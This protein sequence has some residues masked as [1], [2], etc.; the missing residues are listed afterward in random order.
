M[1]QWH[2]PPSVLDSEADGAE[3]KADGAESKAD[4]AESEADGADSEAD[5]NVLD[6]VSEDSDPVPMHEGEEDVFGCT[7]TAQPAILSNDELAEEGLEDLPWDPVE[8]RLPEGGEFELPLQEFVLPECTAKKVPR[9][10]PSNDAVNRAIPEMQELVRPRRAKG[11]GHTKSKLDLVTHTR[12]ECVLRFLRLYRTS[13][14]AAWSLHSETIA[15]TAGKRGRKTWLARKLREWAIDFCENEK[16]RKL[17]THLLGQHNSCVLTDEDVAG[18]IHQ[19]LQSLGKWV[20]AKDIA[21]YVATPEFQARLQIKR[22][23]SVRTAQRWMK[24]MGYRWRK[25]PSGMYSDGHERE[26]IVHYWQNVFLPRWRHLHSRARWWIETHSQKTIDVDA[27]L[28][29]YLS[30]SEDARV[31]VIWCHDESIFY[32]NDQRQIRWVG[33]SETPTIKAKGEGK[34]I[35]VGDYVCPD[36]GWMR[37]KTPNADGSFD[38]ARV[39][40]RPGKNR[41]GYQTIEL[42]LA[43]ATK[44]M[45]VLD[46]EYRDEHHVFAYDNARIHTARAPDGLSA[47][48]MT[49]GPSK[50]FNK[51]KVNGVQTQVRMQDARFKMGHAQC[52]YLPDGSFKGMKQLIIERRAM[53]HDLPDPDARLANGRKMRGKCL[54]FGCRNTPSINCCMKKVLYCE[55][56]FKAQ[57]GMLE[58]HCMKRGYEVIFFPKYH[59]ELNFI[60]Q[61]WGYAKRIYR[62]YP[63]TTNEDDLEANVI[64]ALES[65]PI[66]SMQRFATRSLRFADGYHHGLNGAE[67]AWA[68]KKYRGHQTLPPQYLEH[69]EKRKLSN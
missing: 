67:A 8:E 37:A 46:K 3:S 15:T 47:L 21:R 52:L 13:G 31:V 43:Q 63:R 19:H 29:A 4:G 44:A 30:D 41:D 39:V 60:E 53:G 18:S 40:L 65:V 57:M 5:G 38:S 1:E 16:V 22:N 20:S 11:P 12:L 59:P 49:V 61:C 23:I 9:P 69:L 66:D 35:M 26:D 48:H 58:E 27:E 62:M 54:S 51:T 24:K 56:D 68:N 42:I 7:I 34:S 55:P 45:N 6:T 50:N 33:N 10:I 17:P 25:E 28:C 32:G 14:Y 64:S 2:E 36:R